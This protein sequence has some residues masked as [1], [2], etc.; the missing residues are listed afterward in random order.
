MRGEV[1]QKIMSFLQNRMFMIK[2]LAK[3]ERSIIPCARCQVI[4]KLDL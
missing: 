3:Q 2:T 1:N 4:F